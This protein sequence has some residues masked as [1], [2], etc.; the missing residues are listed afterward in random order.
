MDLFNCFHLILLIK[1][2]NFQRVIL[3]S[4]FG[5]SKIKI[6]NICKCMI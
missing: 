2:T 3:E 4:K 5:F 1:N 6:K